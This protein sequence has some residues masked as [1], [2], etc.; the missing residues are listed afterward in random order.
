MQKSLLIKVIGIGLLGLMLLMPLGMI[1]DQIHDRMGYRRIAKASIAQSWTGPQ[2][3][4]GPILMVPYTVEWQTKV[5][6]KEAEQYKDVTRSRE[7]LLALVPDVLSI[8]SDV[9][10]ELRQRGIFSVPVYTSEHRFS[11]VFDLAP[12]QALKAGDDFK[13]YGKPYL[14][15]HIADIR[16]IAKQPSLTW[17][18]EQLTFD[19]GSGLHELG[20]GIHA[21]LPIAALTDKPTVSFSFPL[22]L[23]GMETVQF[24]PVAKNHELTMRSPWP[25]PSFTGRYLPQTREIDGDGFQAQWQLSRF[26]TDIERQVADCVER[27]CADLANNTFGVSLIEPV[28]VYVKS[29]RSVKYGVLFIGLTFVAFFLIELLKGL[30]IHPMQYLL[31]GLGLSLFFLLLLSLAEHVVFGL[32]YLCASA[33]CVGL[34]AYY[35]RFVLRSRSGGLALGVVL[36]VLYGVLFMVIRSEDQALLMGSGLL[37]LALAVIMVLTRKLD[38]YALGGEMSWPMAR[39]KTK[40]AAEERPS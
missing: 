20:A 9:T 11:G 24:A 21:P 17:D 18:G 29:E 38:W 40:R 27:R 26:A 28:D 1:E 37:F 14:A 6:D 25:H 4:I 5:W 3:V 31:V 16:G 13:A 36:S 23:R 2:E 15:I 8:D 22:S 19:S 30:R 33:A 10:T 7:D 32:A 35:C 34:L 12:V 39:F